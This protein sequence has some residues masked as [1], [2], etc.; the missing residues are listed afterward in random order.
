MLIGDL[1][2]SAASWSVVCWGLVKTVMTYYF[3]YDPHGS[4]PDII[5]KGINWTNPKRAAIWYSLLDVGANT[6]KVEWCT[7]PDVVRLR[8]EAAREAGLLW[9]WT[10]KLK[11]VRPGTEV[12]LL[13]YYDWKSPVWPTGHPDGSSMSDRPGNFATTRISKCRYRKAPWQSGV[14]IKPSNSY[15]RLQQTRPEL[16]KSHATKTSPER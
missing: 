10:T 6:T 4:Q 3:P 13:A 14:A 9:Q 1:P 2:M 5:N 8:K 16:H 7:H 12:S 11:I 15:A